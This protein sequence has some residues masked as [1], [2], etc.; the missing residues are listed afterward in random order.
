MS[1]V[2]LGKVQLGKVQLLPAGVWQDCGNLAEDERA[3]LLAF[4]REA[5]KYVENV[6]TDFRLLHTGQQLLPATINHTE[7]H[8]SYVCSPYTAFVSY[9]LEE[10]QKLKNPALKAGLRLLIGGLSVVL[11]AGRI[12]CNVHVN[13][14]LLSTNLYPAISGNPIGEITALLCAS[15]P[16]HAII[17]RSL[18]R[19]HNG[20]L[21]AQLEA[22]GYLLVPSRQVYLFDGVEASYLKKVNTRRDMLLLARSTYKV[23]GHEQLAAADYERMRELYALLYLDKYSQ[24]NPRFSQR[25]MAACHQ[26]RLLHLTGLRDPSGQ[27]QGI[28]GTFTRDGITTTPLVGYNTA[29]PQKHGLYRM[30]MALVLRQ[31]AERKL[32]LNLSAGASHFKILR[33]GE[34]Q[35]EYA[36]LYNRHL[37]P[38]RRLV[39]WGL[40]T[41]LNRIGVPLLKKYRL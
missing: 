40:R 18:N 35:I 11:K 5:E 4:V 19:A 7:Y 29:L 39:V 24:H 26:Q 32:Q 27:L 6:V 38:H 9:A 10:L 15:F 1:K 13:N 36:A 3:W 22:A 2:Q 37:R 28:V 21:M 31:V 23:V 30:L 17:F 8:S 25:F 12:N 14:W 20:A 16:Q 33:G 41:I 34:A